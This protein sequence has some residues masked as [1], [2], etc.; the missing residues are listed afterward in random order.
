M[1]TLLIASVSALI[2]LPA[3]AAEAQ[4]V[5]NAPAAQTPLNPQAN[6][7]RALTS[8]RSAIVGLTNGEPDYA[9]MTPDLATKIRAKTEQITPLLRQFGPLKNAQ[10]LGVENGAEKFR[11]TFENQTTEWL[12]GFNP[13]GKI[14]VLLFRP[15]S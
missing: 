3:F 6:T 14:S 12:I 8:L 13:N 11:V 10:A 5:R 2:T 9:S 15:V 1:K 7:G 4:T